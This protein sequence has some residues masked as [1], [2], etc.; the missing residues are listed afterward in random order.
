MVRDDI[1][2]SGKFAIFSYLKIDGG[3]GL[4]LITEKW[5][6]MIKTIHYI[7]VKMTQN[8]LQCNKDGK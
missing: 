6:L 1:K 3:G 7:D 8:D 5:Q 2:R 4:R